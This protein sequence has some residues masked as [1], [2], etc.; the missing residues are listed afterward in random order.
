[1]TNILPIPG[2]LSTST[3][4]ATDFPTSMQIFSILFKPS[5]EKA[6]EQFF[7][8]PHQLLRKSVPRTMHSFYVFACRTKFFSKRNNLNVNGAVSHRAA[9]PFNHVYYPASCKN[10]PGS[11]GEQ[12]KNVE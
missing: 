4:P 2:V 11:A 6:P 3:F 10:P 7:A 5:L 12:K 8:F 9:F 1:M